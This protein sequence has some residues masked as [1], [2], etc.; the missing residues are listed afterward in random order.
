MRKSLIVSLLWIP[1]IGFSQ[2]TLTPQEQLEQAQRQLEEAQ[3]ALKQAQEKAEK[4]KKDAEAIAKLEEINKQI[5]AT[6]AETERLNAET[7]KIDSVQTAEQKSETKWTKPIIEKNNMISSP[8]KNVIQ[9]RYLAKD[10]VP[11]VD[12]QVKWTTSLSAPNLTAQQIYEKLLKVMSGFTQEKEQ[13]PGSAVALVNEE[14]HNIVATMR[15]WLT[16]TNS[17]LSLDRSEMDYILEADCYDGGATITMSR[18]KYI[19]EI[20]GNVSKYSAENWITDATSVNKK[21]TKLYPIAGKFR[22]GT[23][24][25]KDALFKALDTALKL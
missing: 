8:E 11:I 4:A 7:F 10:A 6:K 13:L 3:Q 15:E 25:R 14:E 22:R 16:F 12:G 5:N 19:Y 17:F 1:I 20:Q 18:I 21:R 23:I 9:E 2:T 24:D